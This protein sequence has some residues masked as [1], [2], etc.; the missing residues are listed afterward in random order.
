MDVSL[1]LSTAS[2]PMFLLT[3]SSGMTVTLRKNTSGFYLD[4]ERNFSWK[5]APFR[6]QYNFNRTLFPLDSKRRF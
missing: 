2:N 4:S 3:D 6:Y 1:G 5:G